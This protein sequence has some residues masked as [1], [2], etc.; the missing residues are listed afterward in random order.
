MEV[1]AFSTRSHVFKNW[2]N[3]PDLSHLETVNN[4]YIRAFQHGCEGAVTY[5]CYIVKHDENSEKVV[6]FGSATY[7]CGE[8]N[9][10]IDVDDY[11]Y[12]VEEQHKR[13]LWVEGLVSIERGCGSL[14][15]RVLEEWLS[16]VAIL[17]DLDK[18]VIN[19]MSVEESVG[20]YEENGYI[21]GYTGPRFSG[22]GNIRVVKAVLGSKFDISA[23]IQR[24][25]IDHYPTK[26]YKIES[27]VW[28]IAFYILQG[29]RIPLLPYIDIPKDV[30][31]TEYLEYVRSNP[32][33]E[34][35]TDDMKNDIFNSI[36]DIA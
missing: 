22:T 17:L 1:A 21:E 6:A 34:Y 7:F 12:T 32:F 14:V 28:N 3:I 5:V 16:S 25:P 36:K 33:V 4:N 15:L 26:K 30:P 27:L 35:V 24:T 29:R 8:N 10:Y 18:K 20:F 2:D 19:I 9:Y 23:E 13:N 31:R 11:Q